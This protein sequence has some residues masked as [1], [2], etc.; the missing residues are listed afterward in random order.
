MASQPDQV[1]TTRREGRSPGYPYFPVQK[2]LERAEQLYKEEAFHWAPLSSATGAWGYSPKSSGGRQSIATMK[3]YGLIEVKGEGDGRQIRLSELAKR[4]LLDER[5]DQTE[6][7]A[8]IREVALSPAAHRSLYEEYHT[9]LPSDGTV[10]HFLMFDRGYNRDAA[11]DLLE[12]FK[13][14]ASTISLYEPQKGVD[15]S[16]QEAENPAHSPKVKVG[17]LIQATVSGE[18]VFPKGARVLGFSDDGEWVF[19]DQAKG[20]LKLEEIT[21][22]EP[23]QTA[24]SQQRP[25]IPASLLAAAQSQGGEEKGEQPAGTRK[26]VFPVSEGD[27]AIIFPRDITAEGLKELGMYL[28]IFLK[29]EEAAATKQ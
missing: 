25:T 28:N 12:E 14:T 21:V 29:K 17:D 4:I 2:A 10:L 27:V 8:L 1:S 11:R 15:K 22:L 13:Q 5:D 18:D 19:T 24:P 7:R 23:A 9:G 3:Y 26:A 6:K 16:P 20:G